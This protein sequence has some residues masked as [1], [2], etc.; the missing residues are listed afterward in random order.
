MRHSKGNAK[1]KV[2]RLVAYITNTETSQI[3][4]LTLHLKC[5]KNKE[6]ANLIINILRETRTKIT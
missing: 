5:Y 2:Y 1:G 6:Q 3:N 4:D